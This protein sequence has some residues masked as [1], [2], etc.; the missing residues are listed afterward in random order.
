MR[1]LYFAPKPCW[2]PTT[3]AMLRNYHLARE[4]A[5]AARVTYLS[6]SEDD[7]AAAGTGGL[8]APANPRASEEAEGGPALWC[9]RVVEVAR[10]RGYTPA[11]LARGVL[12]RTPVTV[13][14]YTTRE[15]AR[16]LERVLAAGDFHIV[17]VESIHLAAYLPVIRAA[18]SHPAVILDWHNV[19]SE[20][21]SRYAERA[22]NLLRRA[23]AQRTARQLAALEARALRDFDAHLTVSERDRERLFQLA[24]GARV[25]VVENGV[26]TEH[27]ADEEVER[28]QLARPTKDSQESRVRSQESEVRSQESRA[29]GLDSRLSTPDSRLST[30]D[31]GLP[32]RRVVFVGSMDYHANVDAVTH[33][34]REVWPRLRERLP[35]L[36]FSI[37]GRAPAPEVRALAAQPGVEVT[38][39]VADVRPY[40]RDALAAVIPLRVGGGSRLKILE[41]MA[42]G[43]PVVSTRLGAEGI[44]ARDG[45]DIILAESADE[46]CDAVARLAAGDG[47]RREL[48]AAGRALV[49][50]RYDWSSVGASLLK[51]YEEML[52][53]KGGGQRVGAGGV[54]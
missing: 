54:E 16:E 14:N 32:L 19:E 37:V 50:A 35:G 49:R 48:V 39:T 22:P 36:V 6:F 33:F 44:D 18:R 23:Y 25:H 7:N 3:G 1:L 41:A 5:R 11:K 38:G 47:A 13:L 4:T 30:P 15:M 45:V 31:S 12:G 53:G 21:M 24:P 51:I 46:F 27:F 52:G 26:A 42:A 28:A 17:Q 10:G 20:I 34:A 43:V 29:S 2:P 9:E 8:R 40:Y